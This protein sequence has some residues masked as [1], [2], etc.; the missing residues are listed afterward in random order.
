MGLTNIPTSVFAIGVCR[1]WLRRSCVFGVIAAVLMLF[2]LMLHLALGNI[3]F[4][5]LIKNLFRLVLPFLISAFAASLL[6]RGGLDAGLRSF[7]IGIL[8]FC[9]LD[10]LL[11]VIIYF[12]QFLSSLL[13]KNIYFIKDKNL[14]LQ[15]TN[16]TAYYCY[17]AVFSLVIRG[18]VIKDKGVYCVIWALILLLLSM[19]RT[20]LLASLF[21]IAAP[22]IPAFFV[23]RGYCY[24]GL[25][26]IFSLAFYLV[27][28]F[29][30]D[31]ALVSL[32]RS[33][34]DGSAATKFEI[35]NYTSRVVDKNGL[36]ALVGLGPQVL[37]MNELKTYASHS[38]IGIFSELGL[39]LFLYV[40]PF[41]MLAHF[42]PRMMVCN[43]MFLIS[44]V[45]VSFP[46][47][48]MSPWLALVFVCCDKKVRLNV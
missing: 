46:L 7:A 17:V 8:I 31:A 11:P 42:A 48:Y 38:M 3:G 36:F 28:Y 47:A 43:F 45:F 26:A 19:S 33:D 27:C 41:F 13:A 32:I 4:S 23:K 37:D 16:Y 35:I 39:A 6:L 1:P 18:L 12:P 34:Y 30:F 29:S 14:F 24:V 9:S 2:F 5:M 25:I 40:V 20:F 21:M 15:N 22:I 10:L 44:S